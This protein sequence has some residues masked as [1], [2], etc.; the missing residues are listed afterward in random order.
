VVKVDPTFQMNF[1]T[2]IT[3]IFQLPY[4]FDCNQEGFG[5]TTA[6]FRSHSAKLTLDNATNFK[7]FLAP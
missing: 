7:N 2:A 3:F 4:F 5:I 1:A 6:F